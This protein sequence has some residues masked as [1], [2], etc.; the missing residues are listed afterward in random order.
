[1]SLPP[2]VPGA[3]PPHPAVR[4]LELLVRARY[5]LTWIVTHEE[6]RAERLLREVAS[7]LQRDV[8]FWSITGGMALPY[9]GSMK[10]AALRA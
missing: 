5:P 10:L 3:P 9:L 2:P 1:M 6:R 8:V 4:E 7:R